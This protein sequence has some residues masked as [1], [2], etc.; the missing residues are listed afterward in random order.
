MVILYLILPLV[1]YSLV[2]GV[3]ALI[4]P[5]QAVTCTLL[6]AVV[7]FPVLC[8]WPYRFDQARRGVI[9]PIPFRF[10]GCLPVIILLG[11]GTCISVNNI[12]SLTPLPELSSGFEAVRDTFYSPPLLIQILGPGVLI[13]AAEEMIFRGLMFAPLRDRMPFWPAALISA[14]LFGLYHGNLLQ[15][16]YAFLLGLVLAWLYER[17]QTLAAPWLFH[18]AANMTSI[19][20]VNTG[21][22]IL[23]EKTDR[24]VFGTA[25][26]LAA[27][28]SVFCLIRIERKTN[29]KEEE[30]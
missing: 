16:V 1:F 28:L 10:R 12:I 30:V 18:A 6:G 7:T 26:V 15:G 5:L 20:A 19:I 3:I 4:L 21:L 17:F 14:V 24:F 22:E 23:T 29:I 8:Y 11:I 2:T 13:P 27:V 9:P 25:L